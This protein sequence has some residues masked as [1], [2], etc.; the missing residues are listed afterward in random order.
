[1]LSKSCQYAI[2]SLL[3]ICSKTNEGHRVTL[4]SIA[5]A[6]DSPT[7]FTSKI[8]QQL[9]AAG[10]ITSTKGGNGGFGINN[11]VEIKLGTIIHAIDGDSIS[12]KC[13]LGL[14]ECSDSK[15]CPVHHLYAPVR[16]QINDSIM[17]ISLSQLINN[18]ELTKLNL[19]G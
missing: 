3:Y 15:P 11:F 5:E 2:R 10:L 12:Q 19:K 18:P 8:L 13:F 9:V 7:A 4:S 6:I 14:P 1:M 16:K 17:N